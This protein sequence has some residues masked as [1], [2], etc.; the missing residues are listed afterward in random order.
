MDNIR[1]EG[2]FLKNGQKSPIHCLPQTYKRTGSYAGIHYHNYIEIL[3]GIDCDAT[4]RV[5][6]KSYSFQNG[7]VCFI[8]P[9]EAHSVFSNREENNYFVIKF[10]PEIL[11]YEG[12]NASE[13][14]YLYP[15]VNHSRTFAHVIKKDELEDA[16]IASIIQNIQTDW[17][18]EDSGYEFSVRG[19]ILQLFSKIV[20]VWNKKNPEEVF[21]ALDNE[22]VK[23]IR[24]AASF[25][26]ERLASVTEK[27]AADF[28]HMSYSHFSRSFKSVMG[29]NFT[30][31]L[32]E[33]RL[34]YA[35]QLLLTTTKSITEI[36]METGFS[37]SSHFIS[38]F[39]RA[40]G[41]TPLAYR[42]NANKNT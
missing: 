21:S 39:C 13:L 25:A 30:K 17:D 16:N 7:D 42:K 19:Q 37:S 15:I 18:A 23:N 33:L 38:T 8:N 11:S 6:G 40:N 3:Y 12:Q 27:D 24:H 10:L 36:S 14:K 29:K 32:S 4:V 34:N 1:H 2:I 35:K 31:F 22:T 9:F 20:R 5:E 26:M 41:V 28:A